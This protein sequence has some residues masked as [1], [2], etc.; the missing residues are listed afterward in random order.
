MKC[1]LCNTQE[2]TI[3]N[4]SVTCKHTKGFLHLPE[5]QSNV[6]TP[7]GGYI[8][9]VRVNFADERGLCCLQFYVSGVVLKFG[10]AFRSSSVL[11]T[12]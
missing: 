6:Y 3:G 10:S 1:K 4:C 5:V 7:T 8:V 9:T 2:L 11:R 12:T